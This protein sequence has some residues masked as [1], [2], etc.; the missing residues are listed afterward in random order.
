TVKRVVKRIV[1]RKKA[2][3]GDSNTPFAS[4]KTEEDEIEVPTEKESVEHVEE[5]KD[6]EPVKHEELSPNDENDD[7]GVS[8]EDDKDVAEGEDRVKDVEDGGDIVLVDANN[9]SLADTW[10]AMLN[11]TRTAK[12]A[13]AEPLRE[14]DLEVLAQVKTA[15]VA[16]A[17]PLREPDPEVLAQVKYVFVD[18]LP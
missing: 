10:K 16:F 9:I 3:A 13:F 8:Q 18:G 15:K 7:T 12:V 4:V 6:V 5:V 11:C 1:I 2:K 17:E 14:L